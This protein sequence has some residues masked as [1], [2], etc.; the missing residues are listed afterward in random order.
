MA[1]SSLKISKVKNVETIT[2]QIIKYL[3]PLWRKNQLCL[4]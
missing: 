4:I 2:I 3:A 1:F